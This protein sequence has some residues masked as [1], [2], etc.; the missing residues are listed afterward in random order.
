MQNNIFKLKIFALLNFASAPSSVNCMESDGGTLNTGIPVV[1]LDQN[2]DPID[3]NA[4]IYY[5]TLIISSPE[6]SSAESSGTD[7]VRV[8]NPAL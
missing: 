1:I 3:V 6:C 7:L 8:P 2:N 4:H 5:N